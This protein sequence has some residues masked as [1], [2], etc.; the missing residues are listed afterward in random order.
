MFFQD[1]DGQQGRVL[2]LVFGV[3]ALLV[4]LV[5]GVGIYRSSQSGG[6]GSRQNEATAKVAAV[7]APA[8]VAARLSPADAASAAQAASDAVSVKVE[9]GV[10]KFYFASGKADL[11]AGAGDALVDV[12]KGATG[13][14]K[15]LISGFHDATGDATRN[16]ELARQRALAVRHALSSAGVP[17]GLIELKKPETMAAS[18]S[19]AEARR[20]EVSVQ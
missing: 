19:D 1:A 14:R 12:I 5:I 9:N 16:I 7:A 11:A 10:V 8:Q 4:A 15:L 2:R 6:S 17:E 3:T 13:G 18:G 20:V